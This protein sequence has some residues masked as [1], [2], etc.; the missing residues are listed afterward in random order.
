MR[1]VV[2]ML[3]HRARKL[4]SVQLCQKLQHHG[5]FT[6]DQITFFVNGA[7]VL[8]AQI[9]ITD[10]G[11]VDERLLTPTPQMVA[12]G[13]AITLKLPERFPIDIPSASTNGAIKPVI[14]NSEIDVNGNVIGKNWLAPPT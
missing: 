8:D 4:Y 14:I 6:P 1:P 9:R 13:A 2:C 3:L 10:L 12:N 5:R 11:S 7:M